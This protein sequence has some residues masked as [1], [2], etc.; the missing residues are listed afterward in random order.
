MSTYYI[1]KTG[2]NQ[3]DMRQTR[4]IPQLAKGKENPHDL[5]V[6]GFT[7]DAMREILAK[8]F[9][10]TDATALVGETSTGFV[11]SNI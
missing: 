2:I 9:V 5:M 10:D 3:F 7:A 6:A 11:Y 1:V 4:Y 8:W